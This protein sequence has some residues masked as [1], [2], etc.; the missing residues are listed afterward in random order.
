[1][2]SLTTVERFVCDYSAGMVSVLVLPKGDPGAFIG[3]YVVLWLFFAVSLMVS[4]RFIVF[5]LK[6]Q[7]SWWGW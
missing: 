3:G 7:G 2:K 1:M 4:F 5:M 6:N